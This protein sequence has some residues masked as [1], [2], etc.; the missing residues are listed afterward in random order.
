MR[1]N[2]EA[3]THSH[4]IPP[5][6]VKFE[7]GHMTAAET[8]SNSVSHVLT[9]CQS[10]PSKA[11]RDRCKNVSQVTNVFT[12]CYWISVFIFS[13]HAMQFAGFP[14]P[15]SFAVF[16]CFPS[17]HGRSP[18]HR[19]SVAFVDSF[20]NGLVWAACTSKATY[21]Q[22]RGSQR[23]GTPRVTCFRWA[24]SWCSCSP[25]GHYSGEIMFHRLEVCLRGDTGLHILVSYCLP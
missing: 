19:R 14:R 25:T 17:W 1:E 12:L 22:R 8:F 3:E 21:L 20:V 7:L 5:R 16:V 24:S 23:S 6:F 18:Y 2:T 13:R 10:M 11:L 9:G 15:R 4:V